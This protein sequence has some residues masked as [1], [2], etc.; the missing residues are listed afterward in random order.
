MLRAA[1]A[2]LNAP[3]N[4]L[5]IYDLSNLLSPLTDVSLETVST[6]P[7]RPSWLVSIGKIYRLKAVSETT[8]Q[9]SIQFRYFTRQLPPIDESFL[10]IYYLDE[11][12]ASPRWIPLPT[13]I[14]AQRNEANTT[15]AS[16]QFKSGIYMLGATLPLPELQ[17]GWNLAGYPLAQS[18][19]VSV[20]LAS[21]TDQLAAVYHYDA[22]QAQ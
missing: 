2:P 5:L 22:Q 15:L 6:P 16:G 4:Q 14:N 17:A 8:G 20:A 3:D 21:I 12:A 1:Y 19:P 9:Y 13:N 10:Q 18:Q 7:N 11:Q